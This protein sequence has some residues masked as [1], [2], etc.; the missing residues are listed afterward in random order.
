MPSN[1]FIQFNAPI[2]DS[3]NFR[4]F[5]GFSNI[6]VSYSSFDSSL[7]TPSGNLNQDITNTV[8]YINNKYNQTNKYTVNA[9]YTDSSIIIIDNTDT[10]TFTENANNTGGRL[11]LSVNNRPLETVIQITDVV[12]SES[13]TNPCS[14]VDVTITTN[15]QADSLGGTISQPV[16]SN[17]FTVTYSRDSINDITIVTNEG[18][19][20]DVRKIFVPQINSSNFDLDILLSPN[21]NTI[22]VVNDF[23]KELSISIQYSIDNIFFY[24]S[25]SFSGVIDSI[26]SVYIKDNAGC[27]FSLPF[28]ITGFEPNV[29]ERVAISTISEQNSLIWVNNYN[30]INTLSYKENTSIN[31]RDFKQLFQK[32]DGILRQQLRSSYTNID[33][34]LI[35]CQGNE[36][37]IPVIKK[38]S[39]IGITDVRDINIQNLFYLG[40][41]Y[42]GV[43]YVSG[44]TYDPITL[45]SNGDYFLGSLTPSFMEI[46]DYLQVE[47]AG[48]Y[49]VKDKVFNDNIQYLVLDVLLT[50]FPIEVNQ[51]LKGTAVYNQQNYEL[52]EFSIDLSTLDGDYYLKHISTDDD[53][54]TVEDTTEYFNVS[55]KQERTYK[56]DYYNSE[57]NETNYSTGIRNIIRIPYEITLTYSPSDTQDVYLTDTNAVN[58]ES[59]FRDFYTLNT[60]N[61]PLGFV[62]KIGL[63]VSNDRLFLEGLSLLKNKEIETERIGATNLYKMQIEFIR[64]NYAFVSIS[65]DGSITL[66]SGNPLNINDSSQGLLFVN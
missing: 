3:D 25:S 13:A 23:N 61:I 41:T 51:T 1:A 55:E 16:N 53:F 56:L 38:S 47:G 20:M 36:T 59:T 33:I 17:P 5:D 42:V 14:N 39:N 57:N 52:Y 58:I 12:V 65:D 48:W 60:E 64:S 35:D 50:D 66:P 21:N 40:E 63:A 9:N 11:T 28:E 34:S 46:N 19:N 31:S 15:I 18:S 27:S 30:I 29:Y 4:F 54:E 26:G 22:T 8:S 6:E 49:R 37:S 7:V 62:R 44:N 32:N 43:K 24:N 2:Q 45:Q 10:L